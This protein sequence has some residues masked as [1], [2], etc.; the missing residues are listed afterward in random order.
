MYRYLLG[1]EIVKQI[2]VRWAKTDQKFIFECGPR[3]RRGSTHVRCFVLWFFWKFDIVEHSNDYCTV[4]YCTLTVQHDRLSAIKPDRIEDKCN[5]F[6]VLTLQNLYSWNSVVILKWILDVVCTY[7][8]LYC[9]Q[10]SSRWIEV[11]VT[12]WVCCETMQTAHRIEENGM[13]WV[14]SETVQIVLQHM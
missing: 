1:K 13:N 2:K 5:V 12:N 11:R 7:C 4:S 9:C 6:H 10:F 8:T 14:G 3:R